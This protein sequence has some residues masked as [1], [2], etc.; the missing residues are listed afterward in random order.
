[1]DD[2]PTSEDEQ[3]AIA[4]CIRVLGPLID[5]AVAQVRSSG[6]TEDHVSIALIG[7]AERYRADVVIRH[8]TFDDFSLN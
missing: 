3:I 8:L 7:L 5:Q 1:M 6:F 2:L 4:R